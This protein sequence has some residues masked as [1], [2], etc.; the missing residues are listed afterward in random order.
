MVRC[1]YATAVTNQPLNHLFYNIARVDHNCRGV[2]EES[3]TVAAS[4]FPI[5]NRG[6]RCRGGKP[7]RVEKML[8]SCQKPRLGGFCH[9][10]DLWCVSPQLISDQSS[11]SHFPFLCKVDRSTLAPREA[12]IKIHIMFRKFEKWNPF[13]SE[14]GIPGV[15]S[16]SYSLTV[17]PSWN[18]TE[19]TLAETP[20]QY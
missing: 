11:S 13:L 18:F 14:P 15:R 8:D 17:R 10:C 1:I 4:P 2:A 5:W 3:K 7:R 20:T 6:A 12:T 19:L 16:N 9:I